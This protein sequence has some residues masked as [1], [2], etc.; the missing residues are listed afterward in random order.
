MDIKLV[1][2]T[3]KHGKKWAYTVT[4]DEA[5]E[6]L[7]DY[8]VPLH[9]ELGVPG[10]V[11]VVVGHMGQERQI[12][13]S[14]YNGWHH[15]D[16]EDLRR[17]ID[18]GWGVGS[19][20]WSHGMVEEDLENEVYRAKEVLEEAIG[21]RVVT[22]VAPG[23]NVNI[24]P[25]IVDALR[26]AG[27]LCAM[28]VTDDINRPDSDLWFLARSSNLH[29]GWGPLW[30]AFDPH[31]RLAQ[32]RATSGWVCDYCHCPSPQIP[33]ENKDVYIDEHRARLEAVLEVGGAE[34]WLATVEEI[35]DYIL[36]RRH[37]QVTPAAGAKGKGALELSL[38]GV[39]QPVACHQVTFDIRVP[40][41]LC[42]CPSLVVDGDPRPAM[43]VGQ[44]TI[45]ATLDL[46]APRTVVIQGAGQ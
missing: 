10:H 42:R 13:S 23:S 29:Q 21:C 12:G 18:M 25:A 17:L 24:T 11:E 26:T 8:T 20:S 46:S 7:F 39:P 36:C 4:F 5:M 2:C 14:S 16:A 15:M 19:H 3:W 34:V 37:V 45:R 44:G 33:H 22:Y 1:P 40:P 35:V 30:S 27:Y 41:S 32:A 6:E 31:H 28:G 38:Q 9:Q 43:L